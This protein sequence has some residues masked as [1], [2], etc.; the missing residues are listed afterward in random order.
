MDRDRLKLRLTNR[1]SE[2]PRSAELVEAFCAGHGVASS[3][4][5]AINVS[6]EELLANTISYGYADDGNHEILV[7]V[8]REDADVVIDIADDARGFDPTRAAPPDLAAPL[9]E[10]PIG[11]LGI[12]LA[13]SMM[14]G[15]EY[16][17]DGQ[18]NR[19]RLRKRI[20]PQPAPGPQ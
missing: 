5:F 18:Q 9:N 20:T 7:Q 14:D 6:L 4:I 8:W 13:R 17:H 10:R 3:A 2:I 15:M 1:L 12:Y 11:G 16:R 19:L